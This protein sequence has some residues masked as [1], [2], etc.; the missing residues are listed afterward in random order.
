MKVFALTIMEK[1]L[2]PGGF[3]HGQSND[4]KQLSTMVHA[5]SKQ[6]IFLNN[7]DH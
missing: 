4:G 1:N 2:E 3:K 6:S 5:R 7:A